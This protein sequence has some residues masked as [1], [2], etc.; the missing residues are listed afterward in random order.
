M[1]PGFKNFLPL[2][3]TPPADIHADSRNRLPLLAENPIRPGILYS[4]PLGGS[5]AGT[6]PGQIGLHGGGLKALQASVPPRVIDVAILVTAREYGSA[7]DWTVNAL[8]AAQHGLDPKVID[9]IRNRE[10]T[11][12]LDEPFASLIA[13][14]REVHAKHYVTTATY[15]RAVKTFGER[16]LVALVQVMGQHAGEAVVLAAFDQQL[17]PGQAPLCC[18]ARGPATSKTA[19]R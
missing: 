3:F 11:A 16:D 17:P 2:P 6:G 5:P 12:G 8:A 4:R 13:F 1:P 9:V 10:P 15:A 19:G 7:Y 18:T 14:G